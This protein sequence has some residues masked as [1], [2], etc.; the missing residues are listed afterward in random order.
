MSGI[1]IAGLVL[2]AFPLL[3]HAL[4]SYREA[5]D[6]LSDWWRIEGAYRKCR[7][8]LDYHQLMFEGN[9]ERFLLPLVADEEELKDL[10]AD[11]AG[12]SWEDPELEERLRCRLPKSYKIFLDIMRDINDVIELLKKELGVKN[13]K[14]QAKMNQVCDFIPRLPA[15]LIRI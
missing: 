3:I 5:A 10:I 12:D 14:F 7:H 4:E 2:G 8:E 9:I 11:P 15:L 1:E 6:L 13:K